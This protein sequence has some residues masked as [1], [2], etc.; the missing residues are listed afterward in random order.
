MKGTLLVEF[1]DFVEKRH[2]IADVE[3]IIAAVEDQLPSG[4]VYTRVGNYPHGELMTLLTAA[5]EH[6]QTEPT[7]LLRE[8][9]D[10]LMD[11]FN[12]MHPEFF[13]ETEDVF[14]FLELL[15][16]HIHVEVKK[17]YDD[18]RPPTITVERGD[19]DMTVTYE[20]TRPMGIVAHCMLESAG[21]H[22]GQPLSIEVLSASDDDSRRVMRVERV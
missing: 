8:F 18:A 13:E 12:R 6:A 17:L 10:F 22:F 4:A 16:R 11:A 5:C 2:S 15:D 7:V 20:S 19:S 14:E 1:L 3:T 9:S 21:K